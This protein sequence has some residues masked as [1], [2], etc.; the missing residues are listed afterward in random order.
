[1]AHIAVDSVVHWPLK[2][3]IPYARNARTHDDTQVSQIA[4][5]IVEFGFVNPIL[6]SSDGT[7]IAG[8]GRLLAAQQL[9]LEKAPVII[10]DH[11]TESQRRALVIAD[12]KL[13]ENAGWNDELL[14]LELDDLKDLGFNLDIIGFSDDELDELLDFDSASDSQGNEDEVP[15]PEE[16]V[17]SQVGD[18]WLLGDHKLLCGDATSREDINTLLGDELVDMTFTDPPYNVDY[19]SNQRDKIRFN[20]RPILNDNLGEGFYTFLK[21]ALT[22]ILDKTK[23]ACYI[24]MS[25]SEL[26]TLQKAFRDAGGR[27]STF[28]I[29]AKNHFTLGHSDYQRQYESI[30]YGWKQGSDHF[31]CGDRNQTDLWFFNKPNKSDLHP[32]MKPVELVEKAIRNSSKSRDI[33]LDPFGGSGSTLI[34]CEKAN[35]RARLVELDPKYVDVII[36]RWQEY[37]GG[38]ATRLLDSLT[39]N[40][41]EVT[42]A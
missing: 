40:S 24:C 19:G 6:V 7:I 13:A 27:W 39:F 41:L 30:L 4:A 28:I 26:D 18:I 36:R 10:L 11:L 1:M 9:Q 25:S 8:H 21:D 42:S 35:R 17:I 20:S 3:L 37:S 32:T 31:W 23:G 29:W 2:K 22:H 15:E 34:A 14:A 33:V 38:E 5:S 16:S 12:N